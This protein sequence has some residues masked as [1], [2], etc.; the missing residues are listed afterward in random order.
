MNI[1]LSIHLSGSLSPINKSL[2]TMYSR[3]VLV[4]AILVVIIIN[5]Q[6]FYNTALYIRQY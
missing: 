4:L 1:K 5:I 6:Q 3:F 2:P